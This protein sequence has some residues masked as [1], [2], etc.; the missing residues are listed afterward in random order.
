MSEVGPH[1]MSIVDEDHYKIS[2][3]IH[4]TYPSSITSRIVVYNVLD[5]LFKLDLS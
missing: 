1:S 2:E 3:H 5:T 4:K